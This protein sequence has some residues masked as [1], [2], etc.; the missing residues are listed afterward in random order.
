MSASG[1]VLTVR[2]WLI[3][4]NLVFSTAYRLRISI[5]LL[6]CRPTLLLH[7]VSYSVVVGINQELHRVIPRFMLQL[8]RPGTLATDHYAIGIV[9]GQHLPRSLAVNKWSQTTFA[10]SIGDHYNVSFIFY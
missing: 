10:F 8:L 2:I 5:I 9:C 6:S 1:Q 7:L 3:G 4:R